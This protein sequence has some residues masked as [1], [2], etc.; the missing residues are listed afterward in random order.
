M[1]QRHVGGQAELDALLAAGQAL[2]AEGLGLPV[3]LERECRQLRDSAQLYCLC[4]LP[5]DEERPMLSCDYCSDWFHYE[6]VGL[7]APGARTR[8]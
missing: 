5:Y 4:R 8:A 3:A 2:A 7:D 1:A 6:C